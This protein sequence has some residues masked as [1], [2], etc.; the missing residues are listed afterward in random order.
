MKEN[1]IRNTDQASGAGG[2]GVRVEC[3]ADQPDKQEDYTRTKPL[4]NNC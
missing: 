1:P 4:S 3:R 2:G